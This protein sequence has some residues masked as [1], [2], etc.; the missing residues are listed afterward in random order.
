MFTDALDLTSLK[1]GDIVKDVIFPIA[2]VDTTRFISRFVTSSAGKVAVEAVLEGTPARPY[3]MVQVQGACTLCAVLSQCCDV[4]L[5]QN[6][7]PHAFVLCKV[8]AVPKGI[9]KHPASYETLKANVDPYGG[10][11]AFLQNFWFG[12]VM[13]VDG[14]YMADFGQVMTA[15]WIDYDHALKNKIG[16]LDDLHRAMFRVKVGAHFGR[17]AEEDKDAGYEDPYQRSDAPESPRMPYG[18]RFRQ[19]IRL[20]TGRD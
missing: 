15:S 2:R 20:L 1:Q 16:E 9:L 13:G 12:P 18:D 19:A 7:P 5:G 4:A 14:E 11:K 6:P 3:H 17:V 8:V 10:A